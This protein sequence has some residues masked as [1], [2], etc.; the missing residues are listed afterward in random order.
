MEHVQLGNVQ[1]PG[2]SFFSGNA[3]QLSYRLV[4]FSFLH[5]PLVKDVPRYALPNPTSD[6]EWYGE[7]W[8]KYASNTKL[9]PLY[10]GTILEQKTK[11]RIIMNEFCQEAYGT[12]TGMELPKARRL[13]DV[14]EKWFTNL[15]SPL[16]PRNI[17]LPSQLQLQ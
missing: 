8:V 13:R 2:S 1:N 5:T 3:N 16:T 4:A 15:P 7:I 6:P 12:Q 10:L 14:L 11:F 17:V 9:V